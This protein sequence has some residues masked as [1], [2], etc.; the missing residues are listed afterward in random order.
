[1]NRVT[2]AERL[3]EVSP[4]KQTLVIYR[5]RVSPKPKIGQDA[6]RVEASDSVNS[7]VIL[8]CEKELQR[9]ALNGRLQLQGWKD[10][11]KLLVQKR[12]DESS[13]LTIR[14]V[15][16]LHLQGHAATVG[17]ALESKAKPMLFHRRAVSSTASGSKIFTSSG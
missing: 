17:L 8:V 3:P 1:V 11:G 5:T 14:N 15:P 6:P 10:F 4:D 9:R 2:D 13:F 7:I 12:K 16:L